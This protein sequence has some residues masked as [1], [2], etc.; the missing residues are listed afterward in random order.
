M[1]TGRVLPWSPRYLTTRLRRLAGIMLAIYAVCVFP[2]NIKH[3]FEGIHVPPVPEGGWYHGPRLIV[4]PVLVWWARFVRRPSSGRGGN[5]ARIKGHAETGPAVKTPPVPTVLGNCNS[6]GAVA[7]LDAL[8]APPKHLTRCLRN[9][10]QPFTI[11][12]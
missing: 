12:S 6:S 8:P 1:A 5:I 4:Q 2:A 11:K 10:V 3:A 9:Q 7:S